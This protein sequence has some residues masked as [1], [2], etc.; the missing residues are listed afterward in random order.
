MDR[1]AVWPSESTDVKQRNGRGGTA[2]VR[3]KAGRLAVGGAA[4]RGGGLRIDTRR[5]RC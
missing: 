1:E 2:L 5:F 3:V 4:A